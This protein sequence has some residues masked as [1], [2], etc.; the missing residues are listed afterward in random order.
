MRQASS[1]SFVSLE[2]DVGTGATIVKID[3]TE[4]KGGVYDLTLESYNT[5]SAVKSALK[6]DQIKITVIKE[7]I[8]I[9]IPNP[10]SMP[11]FREPLGVQVLTV[12]TAS[13]WTLPTII[14]GTYPLAQLVFTAHTKI[15]KSIKFDKETL[16]VSFNG[17]INENFAR[18]GGMVSTIAIDLIDEKGNIASHT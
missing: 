12:G 5:L 7:A 3:A 4:Q 6:T 18:G 15:N 16:E 2:E 14:E 13:K 8:P 1:L 10:F 11:S 9:S 17:E